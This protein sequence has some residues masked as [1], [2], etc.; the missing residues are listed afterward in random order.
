MA[1][2]SLV[3]I[4]FLYAN[5]AATAGMVEE[6]NVSVGV[7]Q[8]DRD[9]AGGH[10]GNHTTYESGPRFVGLQS[11]SH[12]DPKSTTASSLET[13]T[14]T[15]K[16]SDKAS[17]AK[18]NDVFLKKNVQAVNDVASLPGYGDYWELVNDYDVADRLPYLRGRGDLPK[19]M[20]GLVWMDQQCTTWT[21]LPGFGLFPGGFRCV[22]GFGAVNVNEYLAGFKSWDGRCVSFRRDAWTFG[23]ASK[24]SE[25]CYYDE[26][27]F[28]Q[29]NGD[30]HG[31]CDDGAFFDGPGN[32][33]LIKTSF[34]WDRA[35]LSLAHYPLLQIVDWQGQK[36][37]W[38][39][40]YWAEVS[41]SRCPLGRPNC[42][43]NQWASTNQ[44]ARCL[45]SINR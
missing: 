21:S 19:C 38:F 30:T 41:A 11:P 28:C 17:E 34:G 3:S 22:T 7:L 15:S 44:T 31:P 33:N 16:L 2:C 13:E 1:P 32:F 24:A 4:V 26:V 5:A 23:D 37:K 20:Q 12:P 25:I 39:D 10:S 27:K 8:I 36:T 29:T 42:R 35:T 6:T 43:L 9:Q 14:V 40:Y 45:R 18:F